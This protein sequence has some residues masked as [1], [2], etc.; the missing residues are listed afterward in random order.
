MRGTRL[1]HIDLATI[2]QILRGFRQNSHLFAELPPGTLGIKH[3]V[4]AHLD[5]IE[6]KIADCRILD[7]NQLVLVS[8]DE[9]L[10]LLYNIGVLDWTVTSRQ[11]SSAHLPAVRNIPAPETR[12][13][14]TRIPRQIAYVRQDQMSLWSRKHRLV[15]GLIDGERSC[16]KIGEMLSLPIDVLEEVLRDLQ[17]MNVITM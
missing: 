15:F 13:V 17:S 12:T 11:E 4:G 5:L 6:G 2:L 1:Y 10:R 3:R 9:A 8:G 14:A 16:K 7:S